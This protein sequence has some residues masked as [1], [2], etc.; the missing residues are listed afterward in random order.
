MSGIIDSEV[1][2]FILQDKVK[3]NAMVDVR[4]CNK[5]I[6]RVSTIFIL[7]RSTIA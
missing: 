7:M 5:P 4:A 1:N 2:N 6:E 3:S